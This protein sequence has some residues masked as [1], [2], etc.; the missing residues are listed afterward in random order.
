MKSNGSPSSYFA[1]VIM[2]A[3]GFNCCLRA[4]EPLLL[5]TYDSRDG[6][7][8]GV[9]FS[10][11]NIEG[12]N[13]VRLVAKAT[14]FNIA[15]VGRRYSLILSNAVVCRTVLTLSTPPKAVKQD[16]FITKSFEIELSANA[17]IFLNNTITNIAN[18]PIPPINN[19]Q[20]A[21]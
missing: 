18:V 17:E 2:L 7:S 1:L 12:T 20:P 4:G 3:L 16:R 14:S 5:S 19:K 6:E 9:L 11:S 10:W 13:A 15:P 8:G 21:P